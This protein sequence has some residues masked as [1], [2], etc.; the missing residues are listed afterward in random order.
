MWLS[1]RMLALPAMQKALSL[2]P[3]IEKVEGRNEG[4]EGRREEGREREKE[5]PGFC[6]LLPLAS[7]SEEELSQ[8]SRTRRPAAQGTQPVP[9]TPLSSF[10]EDRPFSACYLSLLSHWFLWVLD[11]EVSNS[12]NSVTEQSSCIPEMW[13][14]LA[15][16]AT[17][18][19]LAPQLSGEL[20]SMRGI[21]AYILEKRYRHPDL[22]LH[23]SIRRFRFKKPLR[24]LA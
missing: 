11:Q 18:G 10:P 21:N 6:T 17:E 15:K 14:K 9:A 12:L 3:S 24:G 4:R 2:V 8:A 20:R 7:S 19:R 16:E 22:D 1:A 5:H 13:S 23:L